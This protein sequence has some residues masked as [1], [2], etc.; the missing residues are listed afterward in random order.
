MGPAGFVNGKCWI[1]EY[2]HI[3]L[4]TRGGLISA[5]IGHQKRSSAWAAKGWCDVGFTS[6]EF[7]GHGV[8]RCGD[9]IFK[10]KAK[11]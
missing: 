8:I 11:T 3:S 4:D 1:H 9:R 7:S 5:G 6:E 10:R 2:P